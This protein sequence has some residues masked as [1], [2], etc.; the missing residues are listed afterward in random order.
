LQTARRPYPA[1]RRDRLPGADRAQ[2][3][4]RDRRVHRSDRLL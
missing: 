3:G 2:P 1:W 4:R